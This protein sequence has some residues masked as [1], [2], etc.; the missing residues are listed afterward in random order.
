MRLATWNCNKDL[1]AKW[2]AVEALGANVLTVQECGPNTT[3][4][5]TS[6]DGW[7]CEWQK[8]TY[9]NGLAVLAR[10]PYSIEA[11]EEPSEPF[12][13]STVVAGPER[14]RFVGVWTR[15]P[16]S[17]A[18]GYPQ[19][20]A[21]L[22][23][24]LPEDGIPTVVA[25]DFNASS[26]NEHHLRNVENL[27]SLGLTS[28]YHSFHNIAHGPEWLHATSYHLRD[29]S[30]P[31]HMDYV[32]VPEAWRIDAV[33]VGTFSEYAQPGGLSDHMPIVVSISQ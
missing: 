26:R 29:E 30:K 10:S 2:G 27:A 13:L 33:E 28:A 17:E 6:H 24:Q 3:A 19:Q 12:F 25:G 8:G 7:T 15:T 11:R 18:D 22:I 16:T 9:R 5:V 14:F 21:R 4:Q 1:A 20:M 32:F 31:H 23:E